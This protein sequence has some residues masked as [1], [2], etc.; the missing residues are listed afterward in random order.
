MKWQNE[1]YSPEK[2]KYN[3]ELNDSYA[4]YNLQIK[5]LEKNIILVSNRITIWQQKQ[6][7]S[8]EFFIFNKMHFYCCQRIK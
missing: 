1:V 5:I 2:F 6:S 7:S 3:W 8:Q 4:T